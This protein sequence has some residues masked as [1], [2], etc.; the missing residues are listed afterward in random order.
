M[1]NCLTFLLDINECSE[2]IS[3]CNQIC[4][5]TLGSYTCA[6]QN[7][8]QLDTDNHTCIDIDECAVNNG[9]CE[10]NCHNTNGSSYCS[11]NRGYTLEYNR[12]SCSGM[13]NSKWNFYNYN[14]VDINE[15][16]DNTCHH[17]CVNLV[18]FFNCT[19]RSGYR[20]EKSRF[21][22]GIAITSF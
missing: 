3:G 17:N 8:Y 1:W 9:G 14:A 13:P 7:G 22:T 5:N 16:E 11:C 2:G 21:C 12:K 18:P 6:C 20:L 15:C 10:Q 19:C 4:S